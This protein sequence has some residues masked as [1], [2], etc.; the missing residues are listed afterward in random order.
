MCEASPDKNATALSIVQSMARFP[1]AERRHILPLLAEL[2]TP[3]ALE[4]AQTASRDS[5]QGL[6]KEA[7]QVLARWPNAAPATQLL[8]LAGTTPEPTL[9]TLALRGAIEVAGQEPDPAKRFA[10]LKRSL[11]AAKQ[12]DEKRQAL[13]QLGQVGSREALDLAL[14]AFA[15]PDLRSEA[16]LAAVSIAEK[17]APSEPK[18][19]DEVG[20]KVLAQFKEG[21]LARRAWSLRIRP[22]SAE[23]FI[24]DW[25]I[26]GPYRQ[27]GITGAEAVF[28]IVFGPEKPNQSVEW[29]TVRGVDSVNLSALFPGQDNCA[30]YL[31]TQITAP[32]DCEG[33]LL[34]GSDDGIKAWLNGQGVHSKNVDRG[35]VVDQD[36]A[37]I[38]LRK[39]ANDLLLKVSQ[40]GGGWSA[41]ARIVGV[42]GKPIPGLLVDVAEVK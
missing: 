36:A 11:S 6:A 17:L 5:D 31:R 2:A 40:G 7:V 30:A 23:A 34:L 41:C 15:E 38:K 28:K 27:A 13:G 39:G 10:L 25:A 21:D 1:A 14:A 29:R 3:A 24:R 42:D 18:L 26:S 8:E 12:P 33:A 9:Q 4:A 20:A 32:D 19:A 37:P 22:S 16:G 35:Q